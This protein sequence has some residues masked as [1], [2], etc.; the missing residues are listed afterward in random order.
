MNDVA[1][2]PELPRSPVAGN[3]LLLTGGGARTAYQAGVLKAI[4]EMRPDSEFPFGV[5]AGASAGSINA[6][7]LA[8]RASQWPQ[9][10]DDLCAV[11]REL[12]PEH[13][14][15]TEM[16]DWYLRGARWVSWLALPRLVRRQPD[17]ILDNS[18]LIDSLR[19]MIDPEAIAANLE[20]GRFDAL[21]IGASSYTTGR[22]VTFYQSRHEIREWQSAD[23]V[24][25][26]QHIT[27]QHLAAS[28][29]IPFVFSPVQLA[30]DQGREWFGDGSVR[31]SAP[32]MPLVEAGA[33]RILAI[34]VSPE[35]RASMFGNVPDPEGR[36]PTLAQV[37]G[38]A[39]ASVFYDA[40]PAE[41]DQIRRINDALELLNRE[42]PEAFPFRP[43]EVL[44]IAPSE[45]IEAIALRHVRE[46][47][48]RVRSFLK[49][50]GATEANGMALAS[51]LL[52][53]PDFTAELMALGEADA[54]AR[55][56]EIHALFSPTESTTAGSDAGRLEALR[57]SLSAFARRFLG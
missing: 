49:T 15:T 33:H 12:R 16:L 28:S 26:R 40:L 20:A 44:A 9:A 52:F 7:F 25:L 46:L 53:E 23:R 10:A 27:I 57:D 42:L 35:E 39:L 8:A 13:V 22:H 5:I 32:L 19:E 37:A 3:G 36:S 56:D 1:E 34:T 29:A 55:A 18:P 48:A 14:F 41:I 51:Y 54:R 17:A 47:P 24:A 2:Q 4:A 43:M 50:F 11:W 6:A 30:T 21:C 31:Q 38:H 45:P